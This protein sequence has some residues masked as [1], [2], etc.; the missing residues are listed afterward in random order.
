MFTK[1]DRT[2]KNQKIMIENRDDLIADLER[3]IELQKQENLALYKE[4]KELRSE[5]EKQRKFASKIERLVN[6]NKYNNEKVVLRKLKELVKDY[7]S[8]N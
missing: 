7:L 1:K 4:N 3:K 5:N 8:I 6:S 2:I